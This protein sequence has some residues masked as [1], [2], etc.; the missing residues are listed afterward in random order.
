MIGK[1]QNC[2]Q[3]GQAPPA[4]AP[5]KSPISLNNAAVKSVQLVITRA[6]EV[7]GSMVERYHYWFVVDDDGNEGAAKTMVT[8]YQML[9]KIPVVRSFPNLD[10][11]LN[12]RQRLHFV[13]CI[14]WVSGALPGSPNS[15]T[16]SG[17]LARLSERSNSRR[18]SHFIAAMKPHLKT[19]ISLA[20]IMQSPSKHHI[21]D[22]TLQQ[23]GSLCKLFGV[24]AHSVAMTRQGHRH[25][26]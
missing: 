15:G 16:V 2:F 7:K 12:Q 22:Q 3:P 25:A 13:A 5:D 9:N 24:V 26:Q 23:S 20:N 17:I 4:I 10:V 14:V 8:Y 19:G 21:R 18:G 1:P 6:S 11:V